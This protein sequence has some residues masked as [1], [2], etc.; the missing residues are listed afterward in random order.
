MSIGAIIGTRLASR[1]VPTVPSDQL[2]QGRFEGVPIR[3]P[4]SRRPCASIAPGEA[5]DEYVN[6]MCQRP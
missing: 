2:K 5:R 4:W 1:D 6:F 3:D